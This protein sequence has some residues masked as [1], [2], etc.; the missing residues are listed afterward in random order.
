MTSWW[1]GGY[2]EDMTG[3]LPGIQA[4]RS[5]DAGTLELVG[6]A[7]ETPSP[8]YLLQRGDHVY[9]VAEG[10]G[11]V[12]SFR[13]TGEHTLARDG[14]APSGGRWPCN[15]EFFEHGIAVANYFDGVVGLVGLDESGAVTALLDTEHGDGSGPH[16]RQ[17]RPHSHAVF[18]VGETTLLSVDLGSDR[19]LVHRPGLRAAASLSLPPGTGPRDIARHPSGLLYVLSELSHELF[20]LRWTG[21]SLEIVSS[22][23]V[24]GAVDGD[25]DSAISFGAGGRYV[26]T[27]LRGSNRISTLRASEDGTHLEPLGWVSSEGDWPRHHAIDGDVLHVANQ[28]S[29]SIASFKAGV[30]GTLRLIAEPI[31]V[32]S[33]NYLLRSV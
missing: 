5:T 28:L 10:E 4:L 7:V 3:T 12:D 23:A 6:T 14:S 21:S 29:N 32:P 33:P 20:V 1:V 11:T 31:S 16:E 18:A 17:L 19:V 22:V 27:G 2:S 8:S 15:L 26:Y 30:D 25:S 9:A 13:R 24:P